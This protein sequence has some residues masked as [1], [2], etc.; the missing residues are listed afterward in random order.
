[1][2]RIV[3]A[4]AFGLVSCASYAQS[5]NTVKLDSLFQVLEAKNKF[6]GSVAI[7]ENGKTVYAKSY[8][9]ADVETNK[10][11]SAATKYRI[12]SVTKTFTACLVLKAVEEGKLTLDQKIDTFFPTVENAK[13]ISI[14]HLLCHRSGIFNFPKSEDFLTYYTETKSRQEMVEIISKGKSVFEPDSASEYSN[15]NYVLLSFILE[16]V[17]HK[18]FAELLDE[19]IAKP[20]GLKNTYF[21]HDANIKN[22]EAYSYSNEAGKWVKEKETDMTITMGAGCIISNPA[23]MT[24]FME[25]LFAHK[26]INAKSLERMLQVKDNQGLGIAPFYVEEKE[27]FGHFG[28]I[29]GSSS[30]LYHFPKEKLTIAIASNGD[31]LGT[32]YMLKA[33]AKICFGKPFEIPA[34]KTIAVTAEELDKYVGVYTTPEIPDFSITIAKENLVLTAQGT[35]EPALPFDAIEKDR[36]EF[37]RAGIQLE[38][39]PAE[40]QMIYSQG[41]ESFIMTRSGGN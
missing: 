1:M 11:N 20:L 7:S 23:D 34:L 15:S 38:F 18:S 22:N 5:L 2:K 28:A 4:L 39:K 16:E 30:I 13:K 32:R 14:E 33:V 29:D 9:K 21:G 37:L 6:M 3:I 19:K 17:Y 27:G 12:G 40:N 10:K 25:S 41:G 24:I 36:F 8:G 35:G 31:V 26:I